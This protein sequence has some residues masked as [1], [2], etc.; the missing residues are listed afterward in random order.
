MPSLYFALLNTASAVEFAAAQGYG[1]QECDASKAKY[2]FQKAWKKIKEI[3]TKKEF[4]S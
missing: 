3:T 4:S 2:M 1:V